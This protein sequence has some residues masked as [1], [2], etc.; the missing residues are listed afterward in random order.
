MNWWSTLPLLL[1]SV[2]QTVFVLLYSVRP[3]G[4]GDWWRDRVGRAL[5][6]KAAALAIVLDLFTAW[7]LFRGDWIRVPLIVGYW[8][9]CAGVFYQCAALIRS[10]RHDRGRRM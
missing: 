1:A 4:A 7:V 8:L 2:P 5:F 6:I 3:F 9:V 10:R